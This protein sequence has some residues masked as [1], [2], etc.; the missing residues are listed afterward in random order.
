MKKWAEEN[1][2]IFYISGLLIW[3][4]GLNFLAH[5]FKYKNIAVAS[6]IFVLFN[7][8]TLYIISWFYFHEKINMQAII[9][10]IMGIMSIVILELA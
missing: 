6:M 4:I 1:K 10:M 3:I 2:N 9:G 7:I 8:I 5:S